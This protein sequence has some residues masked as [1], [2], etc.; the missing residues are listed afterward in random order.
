MVLLCAMLDNGEG[1][2]SEGVDLGKCAE[3]AG[4]GATTDQR[5][6]V[7]SVFSLSMWSRYAPCLYP[8][9]RQLYACGPC[10]CIGL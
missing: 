1:F 6:Q 4:Q 3:P 9:H 5:R 2:E 7:Y 8:S 10:N